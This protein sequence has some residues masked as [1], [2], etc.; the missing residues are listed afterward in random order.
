MFENGNA[1]LVSSNQ[2]AIISFPV[3]LNLVICTFEKAN[4]DNEC[5]SMG[6]NNCWLLSFQTL[7][8]SVV[9]VAMAENLVGI[10]CI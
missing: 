7:I 9:N 5:N 2:L 1:K 4:V 10:L 6:S 3:H 8:F